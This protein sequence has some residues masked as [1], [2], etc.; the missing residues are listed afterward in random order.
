MYA[1]YLPL[2]LDRTTK[3]VCYNW[4]SHRFFKLVRNFHFSSFDLLREP[5]YTKQ[6]T[7]A[8]LAKYIYDL[9]KHNNYIIFFTDNALTV[10]ALKDITTYLSVPSTYLYFKY[11][12]EI[13]F[14]AMKTKK[15]CLYNSFIW[16]AKYNKEI[17]FFRYTICYYT[18]ISV[19][20]L[21]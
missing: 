21:I 15:S 18:E 16:K 1:S 12:Y 17:E 9:W 4:T 2:R 10:G 14:Q 11:T 20:F 5:F 8:A 3:I 7:N 13:S 19:T 6:N